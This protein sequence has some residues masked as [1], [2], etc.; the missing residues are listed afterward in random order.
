M[1]DN[2]NAELQIL[3]QEAYDAVVDLMFEDY[4]NEILAN[5][6]L[7]MYATNSYDCDCVYYGMQ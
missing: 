6:E 2:I 7:L 4:I 1:F 5:E 3:A